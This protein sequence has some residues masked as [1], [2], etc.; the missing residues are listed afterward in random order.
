MPSHLFDSAET[1][2]VDTPHGALAYREVG[3]AT[4]APLLLLNRFRGTLDHWDPA[5]L[6]VLAAHR[7]VIVFDSAGVGYSGGEPADT[8][9]GMTEVAVAFLDALGLQKVDLLGWSM[10][11]FVA[12][13]LALERPERVRRLVVAGSGPG[14]VPGNPGPDPR[15]PEHALREKNDYEDF[16]FLFYPETETGRSAGLD[17]LR[18]I[19]RRLAHS[20]QDVP[21]P[22]REAQ[23][24]AIVRWNSGIDSAWSRLDDLAVPALFANGA[25]DAMEHV[26]Q[27]YAMAQAV[28]NSK[29][30]IYGDAGH[31]FL[32]QH[33]EDF[34]GEVLRFIE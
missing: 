22:V 6:D 3:P 15:V 34:G 5:L 4:A 27:T 32:F 26:Y 16:L 19:D 12:L 11:G 8:V 29:T 14:G 23:M 7:R 20:G 9:R 24:N 17:S 1:R 30:V 13:D 18:R 33:P 25:H 31:A 21:A 10:G 28:P 2:H